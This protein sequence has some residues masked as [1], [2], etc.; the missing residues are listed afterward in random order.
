MKVISNKKWKIDGKYHKLSEGALE[1]TGKFS[2]LEVVSSDVASE[3]RVASTSKAKQAV[4]ID[5]HSEKSARTKAEREDKMSYTNQCDNMIPHDSSEIHKPI[6]VF[7]NLLQVILEEFIQVEPS[8]IF[9]V[10]STL[11][12][13]SYDAETN[14]KLIHEKRK[15]R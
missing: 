2:N 3:L 11:F 8:A 5:M 13:S 10:L 14:R 4:Y 9:P 12:F 7:R 15:H 1:V 6:I